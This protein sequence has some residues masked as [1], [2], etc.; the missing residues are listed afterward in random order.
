MP[1]ALVCLAAALTVV[2]LGA[3]P[4]S[5]DLPKRCG[6]GVFV[7]P[8]VTLVACISADLSYVRGELNLLVNAE[9][10]AYVRSNP[11]LTLTASIAYGPSTTQV[12]GITGPHDCPIR[13]T[14]VTT[15]VCPAYA[16]RNADNL[17]Y[18]SQGY[19]VRG[20]TYSDYAVTDWINP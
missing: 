17:V 9:G 8:G 16:A 20:S 2:S 12:T 10:V 19:A 13:A 6:A 14:S 15:Y 1:R 7:A 11:N 5:A 4:A 18:L 3:A